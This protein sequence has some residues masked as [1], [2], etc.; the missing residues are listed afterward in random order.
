MDTRFPGS[1]FKHRIIADSRPVLPHRIRRLTGEESRAPGERQFAPAGLYSGAM[2]IP[3]PCRPVSAPVLNPANGGAA[4]FGAEIFFNREIYASRRYPPLKMRNFVGILWN[5][6]DPAGSALA[7]SH[8]LRFC[9][10][11]FAFCNSSNSPSPFLPLSSSFLCALCALAVQ[12]SSSLF[13]SLRL[14][15]CLFPPRGDT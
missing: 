8:Y 7:A 4:G 10:L 9:I 1:L 5:F 11:H 15:A 14:P 13:S 12:F 2:M 6:R 3:L